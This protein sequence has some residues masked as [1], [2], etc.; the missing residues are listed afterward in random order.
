RVEANQVK[1]VAWPVEAQPEGT[2]RATKDVLS[3]NARATIERNQPILRQDLVAQGSGL[4][5]LMIP[6]GM[7]GMSVRVD[8][9][10]G[11]SGFITPNRRVDVLIAGQPEGDQDQKSKVVLQ[12]VKVLATG[13]SIEQ[14]DEKPVEVP[15]VTLLVSPEEAERLTLAAR[16]EPVRLALR[17][18]RD[19]EVVKTSGIATRALFEGAGRPGATSTVSEGVQKETIPVQEAAPP[20]RGGA[21]LEP[22]EAIWVRSGKSRVLQLKTSIRRVSIGDPSLAGIV[23]LGPRTIMI[24]AKEAPPPVGGAEGGGMRTV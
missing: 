12:N 16:F 3:S 9:V 23:V 18:Y 10:T 4:L 17:N 6:E 7:R 8:N 13:K 20:S 22:G 15:T 1:L 24:N 11:V 21:M 5:P 2:A 14:K 19:E